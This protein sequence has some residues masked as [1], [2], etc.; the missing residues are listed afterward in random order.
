MLQPPHRAPRV[1]WDRR[2]EPA[3]PSAPPSARAVK[4]QIFFLLPHWQALVVIALRPAQS[5]PPTT[6]FSAAQIIPREVSTF[7]S[8]S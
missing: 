5:V 1:R 2:P 8:V 4:L 7:A 3:V 6:K